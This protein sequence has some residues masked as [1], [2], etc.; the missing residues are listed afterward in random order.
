MILPS[1]SNSLMN[2]SNMVH[3][4]ATNYMDSH[5][6]QKIFRWYKPVDC[7]SLL[8]KESHNLTS[9]FSIV[10]KIEFGFGMFDDK[11]RTIIFN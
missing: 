4:G 9:Y 2:S 8:Q 3:S 6:N 10:S 1:T 7:R 11:K 5:D